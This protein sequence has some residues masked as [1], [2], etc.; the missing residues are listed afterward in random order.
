MQAQA[1]MV[2]AG[3]ARAWTSSND[4]NASERGVPS[5]IATSQSVP[6]VRSP[7]PQLTTRPECVTNVRPK[8]TSTR[9]KKLCS[10]NDVFSLKLKIISCFTVSYF[11]KFLELELI[12]LGAWD[13][14]LCAFH[15][16]IY[17]NIGGSFCVMQL[18][19][20]KPERHL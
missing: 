14:S 15:V 20:P 10:F 13:Y 9:G 16:V 8:S 18:N 12:N 4:T 2:L 1:I 7:S 17:L 19:C 6:R 11:L 3:R 5:P